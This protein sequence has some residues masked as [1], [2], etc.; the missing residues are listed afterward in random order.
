MDGTLL[1]TTAEPGCQSVDAQILLD[2]LLDKSQ[3]PARTYN[4][5]LVDQLATS[6]SDSPDDTNPSDIDPRLTKEDR[7]KIAKANA[8]R[9]VALVPASVKAADKTQQY[10]Q[11]F[12]VSWAAAQKAREPMAFCRRPGYTLS[13]WV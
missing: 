9:L 10:V 1:P 2:D 7:A 5:P 12:L 11:Q 4:P 3:S 6:L 8:E 13:D